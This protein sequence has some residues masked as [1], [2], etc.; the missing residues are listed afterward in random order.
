[1]VKKMNK[2]KVTHLNSPSKDTFLD[3][4]TK[5]IVEYVSSTIKLTKPKNQRCWWC[6]LK[7]DGRPIGCPIDVLFEEGKKTFATDGSFCSFNCVKAYINEKERFD[8][9]FKS[10]HILLAHMVCDMKGIMLPVSV[11]PSPDK[12]LLIEYGGHMTEEQYRNCFDRIIYTE[13]GIIKMFPVTVILQEEEKL[14]NK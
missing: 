12:R 14:N 6:T 4:D 8:V 1:M 11:N 5:K 3:G 13:R 7:I 2:R 9:K 10:S